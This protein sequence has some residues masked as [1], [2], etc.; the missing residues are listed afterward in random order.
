MRADRAAPAPIKAMR[1]LF[2]DFLRLAAGFLFR[3]G[4]FSHILPR[5]QR[6]LSGGKIAHGVTYHKEL[7]RQ[8]VERST[9]ICKWGGTWAL[10]RS[11]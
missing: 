7:L 8:M 4:L 1:T 10:R 3:R 2:L 6:G 9:P 5:C 11:L